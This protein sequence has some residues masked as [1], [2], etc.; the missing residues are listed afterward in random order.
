MS[1]AIYIL[2]FKKVK[3]DNNIKADKIETLGLYDDSYKQ[4]ADLTELWK[5]CDTHKH[6]TYL[7]MYNMDSK[8]STLLSDLLKRG[9]ATAIE[10]NSIGK[11]TLKNKKDISPKEVLYN[12]SHNNKWYDISFKTEKN[13]RIEIK[14]I[15]K[16]IPLE[17]NDAVDSFEISEKEEIRQIRECLLHMF[18]ENIN[19]S[20]IGGSALSNFKNIDMKISTALDYRE[21]FPDL[22]AVKINKYIYG[23][24]SVDEYCRNAYMGGWCYV[25]PDIQGKLLK[26]I[27][28]ITYD[29]NSLYPYVMHG[30]SGEYYPTGTPTFCNNEE[31][32]VEYAEKKEYYYIRFKAKLNVKE[33]G[34]P[35]L[36]V[37]NSADYLKDEYVEKMNTTE[38]FTL[39]KDDF[40]TM[41][42][43]YYIDNFQF[44]DALFFATYKGMFDGFI[45]KYYSDKKNTT[46]AK[47]EI[48]KLMLNS[49]SGKFSTVPLS[50][51]KVA[52]IDENGIIKYEEVSGTNRITNHIATGAAITAKARKYIIRAAKANRD[53]L[54]YSDTDSLHLNGKAK[55]ILISKEI[56]G[57]WK[58]E[59]EFTQ[60][61]YLKKKKYI[62]VGETIEMRMAGVPKEYQENIKE[63]IRE[64]GL[65]DCV[66]K[67]I[68]ITIKEEHERKGGKDILKKEIRVMWE[69]RK[70][71]KYNIV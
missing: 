7:Y 59:N 21:L 41:K 51:F 19:K 13:K 55:D 40:E 3:K 33:N 16:L 31:K 39:C 47:R 12:I 32:F 17:L 30:D 20:T 28:G 49:L 11:I 8:G 10:K 50:N 56:L 68:K 14:D 43:N 36:K 26:N 35:F 69:R 67:G 9:F 5:W 63:N 70:N 24:S 29:I 45:E 46:G 25:N 48:A 27:S 42:E 1:Q 65:E 6:N 4:H 52:K 71:D 18:R 22:D 62:E 53:M 37:K 38:E 66:K 64:R 23:S 60:A 61:I 58:V 57:A 54:L 44:L 2:N 15:K 34:L